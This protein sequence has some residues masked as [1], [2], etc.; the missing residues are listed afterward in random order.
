MLRRNLIKSSFEKATEIQ[1]NEDV[2]LTSK[3]YIHGANG[4][5]LILQCFLKCIFVSSF[6]ILNAAL[7]SQKGIN[8]Q[9]F[10]F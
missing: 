2:S 4:S 6:P 9:A 1:L 5:L 7:K 3:I 10:A 8:Y